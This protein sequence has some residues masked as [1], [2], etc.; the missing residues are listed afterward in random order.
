MQLSDG[1]IQLPMHGPSAPSAVGRVNIACESSQGWSTAEGEPSSVTHLHP[2]TT[3]PSTG[4]SRDPTATSAVIFSAA[5]TFSM[6]LVSASFSCSVGRASGAGISDPSGTRH[7]AG[8][9]G[10]MKQPHGLP[11]R[12]PRRY[13]DEESESI[14]VD[15]IND[16]GI[17]KAANMDRSGGYEVIKHTVK[18]QRKVLASVNV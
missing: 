7:A 5:N 11:S 2:R 10:N 13:L 4:G 3:E 17:S 15:D 18:R 14:T 8:V 12:A 6:R 16:K 9:G 1:N